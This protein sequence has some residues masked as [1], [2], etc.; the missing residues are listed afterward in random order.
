[1]IFGA[2]IFAGALLDDP[3]RDL[4]LLPQNNTEAVS[5]PDI[6]LIEEAWNLVDQNYVDRSALKSKE[7]TYGAIGGMVAALGDEGHTTFLTPEMVAEQ[8]SLTEGEFEGIGAYVEMKDGQPVIVSPI[9]GSPAYDAG[10]NPGDII[11]AVDGQEV[12]GWTVE[13]VVGRIK[14][15]AG[16]QVEIVFMDPESGDTRTLKITRARIEVVNVSWQMLPGTQIAQVRIVSFS[17][18]VTE[19]LAAILK[20]ALEAGAQGLILDLRS[21]PG[22]LLDEAVGVA[23]QFLTEGDVLLMQDARGKRTAEEVLPG[24]SAP[25]TPMVVLIDQG[26]AS[27]S[28]IV[29]GALRDHGR[30]VLVGQT[31]FGTGTVLYEFPLSDGSSLLLAIQEW[32]TPNGDSF[33]HEGITPDVE[34]SLPDDAEPVLPGRGEQTEE[35]LQASKDEQV[36]KAI[37]LLEEK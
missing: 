1:M 21:N 28:E 30:A 7:L 22:G 36:L 15:P 2:G 31:T 20:Q 34:V 26:S 37:E 23:S 9:D 13:E 11:V 16:T 3:L 8:H 35:T 19:D 25:D 6:S 29:A 32:L 24:A 4:M 14:G 27:A 18:G 12:A 33:W 10:V 17:E 5:G